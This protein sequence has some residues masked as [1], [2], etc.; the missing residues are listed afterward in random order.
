ML[1]HSSSPIGEQPRG[2]EGPWRRA[3]ALPRSHL[4]GVSSGFTVSAVG[5]AAGKQTAKLPPCLRTFVRLVRRLAQNN[6]FKG[7]DECEEH[8]RSRGKQGAYLF[9]YSSTKH[10]AE[11]RLKLRTDKFVCRG[12]VVSEHHLANRST[13]ACEVR[14]R[15]MGTS[16]NCADVP[17]IWSFD[18][19]AR[20]NR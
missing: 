7:N 18:K 17:F 15:W 20:V 16:A 1:G 12:K 3:C 8:G 2:Q 6:G 9:R 14:R 5:S 11:E 4:F 10:S 13:A 19:R